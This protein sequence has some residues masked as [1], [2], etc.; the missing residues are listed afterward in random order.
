MGIQFVS[1]PMEFPARWQAIAE[2]LDVPDDLELMALF[3]LGYLPEDQSR[4]TIDW[5]SRHRKRFA[6]FVSRDRVGTP[7][8][9][10]DVEHGLGSEVQGS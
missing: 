2:L 9:D 5:S 3:R 4:P 8:D 1:T 7:A 6:Q 10:L